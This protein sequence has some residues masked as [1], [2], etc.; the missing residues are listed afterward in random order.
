MCQGQIHCFS[1]VTASTIK[2][3]TFIKLS[4]LFKILSALYHYLFGRHKGHRHNLLVKIILFSK[5]NS[6]VKTLRFTKVNYCILN[7]SFRFKVSSHRKTSLWIITSHSNLSCTF[8]I[9]CCTKYPNTA[10]KVLCLLVHVK[11]FLMQSLSF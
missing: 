5:S 2:L 7:I 3:N 10:S 4:L 9:T 8:D 11:S 6:V 1:F